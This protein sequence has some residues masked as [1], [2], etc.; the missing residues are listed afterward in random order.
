MF[1]FKLKSA[2]A[3]SLFWSMIFVFTACETPTGVMDVGESTV[4]VESTSGQT[5]IPT[6]SSIPD[7]KL[8][9]DPFSNNPNLPGADYLHG[10]VAQLRY[11]PPSGPRYNKVADYKTYGILADATLF[12]SQINVPTRSFSLGFMTAGGQPVIIGNGDVLYEYFS[13]HFDSQIQLTA[14]DPVGSYQFAVLSDDGAV[15]QIDRGSGLSNLINNDGDTPTRLRVSQT[16]VVFPDRTTK[17]PIHLDYYQGPR[18]HIAMLLLWRPWPGSGGG[19]PLDGRA[20]N[21]YFFDS[22]KVPSTPQAPYNQLLSRGWQP[23]PA[24]NFILP[25]SVSENPCTSGQSVTT[26]LGSVSPGASVVN[27]TS[28]SFTMG[29]N[30]QEATYLCSLDNGAQLACSNPMSYSGLTEGVHTFKAYAVAQG[31]TD[32]VGVTYTWTVDTIAPKNL[33]GSVAVTSSSFTVTW[34]T[35]E[36]TTSQLNWGAGTVI[37]QSISGNAEFVTQHSVTVTGLSPS[38]IYSYSFGG[39]DQAGNTVTSAVFRTRT[40][41]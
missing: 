30:Y 18:Y 40:S 22:T 37:T 32:S 16:P 11:L 33:S 17:L 10:V 1:L 20:G 12:F 26:T 4:I 29:S 38:S 36:P 24:A 9:C 34:T 31:Q 41:Q 6:P 5:S 23:V 13:V 15:L 3:L 2:K 19:E 14:T 8:V 25:Q 39:A 28:I 35:D 27:S 21:D 7:D